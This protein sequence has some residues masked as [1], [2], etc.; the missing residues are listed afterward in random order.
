MNKTVKRIVS[1]LV[2]A[3]VAVCGI[4]WA[5]FWL[6]ATVLCALI[7]FAQ[8]EFSAIAAKCGKTLPFAG[9][10]AALGHVVA[11]SC[12][13]SPYLSALL[14]L[15]F[16][17]CASLASKKPSPLAALGSSVLGFVFVP[18]LLSH[19]IF[20]RAE[21]GAVA[22]LYL[23]AVVKV[24][25]MGGFALGMAFGKHKMCPSISPN[26]SW[27]GLLGSMLASCI[28]SAAFMPVMHFGVA[29]ALFLGAAAALVGTLGDLV[30]SRFKREAGVKDSSPVLPAG[31]GGF[32]DM[33][34]SLTFAPALLVNFI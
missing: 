7:C 14:A 25:D 3:A 28:V 11:V 1:A 13:A 2:V 12:G 17:S 23:V 27:E 29:K 16:L 19:L 10:I 32:L 31:M 24:S 30:E 15:F 8:I 9:F 5:P 18:F 4:L 21:L 6:V 20:A 34:D 22:M 33:L 26:K